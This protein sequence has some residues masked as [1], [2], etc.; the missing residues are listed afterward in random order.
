VNIGVRTKSGTVFIPRCVLCG[1]D[2]HHG[3]FGLAAA[4]C[5]RGPYGAQYRIVPA[6]GA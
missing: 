1:R 2:H 4:H 6:E 3:E 5:F